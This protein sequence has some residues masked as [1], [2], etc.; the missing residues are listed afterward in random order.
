M[1]LP[2]HPNASPLG[3]GAARDASAANW[4][5]H[6]FLEGLT[7]EHLVVLADCAMQTGFPS[8]QV[9][10]REGEIANRFYLILVGHVDLEAEIRGR[11]PVTVD[12]VE[13]G[14]VLGWSW[15]F[16]P[17]TWNFTARPRWLRW[18]VEPVMNRLFRVETKKRLAAL[19]RFL[20]TN[21]SGHVENP[22]YGS[23]PNQAII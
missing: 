4:K 21:N 23:R 8:G 10:F 6:P 7:P 9:V 11:Q 15:L 16:P 17:Y 12:S 14:D 1:T 5:S 20:A 2:N 13:A 3:D 22:T 18:L 19:A